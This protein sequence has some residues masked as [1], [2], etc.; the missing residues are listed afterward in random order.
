M[1]SVKTTNGHGR[2]R[3]HMLDSSRTI[4]DRRNVVFC[5]HTMLG[6][7]LSESVRSDAPWE[8]VISPVVGWAVPDTSLAPSTYAARCSIEVAGTR[9]RTSSTAQKPDNGRP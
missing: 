6:K 8:H 4:V 9:P 5:I 3:A 7:L 1:V 2:G